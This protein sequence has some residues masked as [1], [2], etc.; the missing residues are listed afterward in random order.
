MVVGVVGERVLVNFEERFRVDV[1]E[2]VEAEVRATRN[3]VL[4]EEE[5]LKDGGERS[6]DK[7]RHSIACH[8]LQSSSAL[9]PHH[10]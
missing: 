2:R 7:L 5:K 3:G 9:L 10:V 8:Q 1:F 6:G 4:V